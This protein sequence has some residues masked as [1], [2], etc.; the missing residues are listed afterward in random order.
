MARSVWIIAIAIAAISTPRVG[1][2]IA[3]I[4]IAISA[5]CMATLEAKMQP[6]WPVVAGIAN[7]F[8]IDPK[9]MP[10]ATLAAACYS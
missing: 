5:L 10:G 7:T 1:E 3:V 9:F 2:Y 6:F 8:G 4:V